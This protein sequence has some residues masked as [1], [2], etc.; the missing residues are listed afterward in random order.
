MLNDFYIL[1]I[2]GQRIG[3]N[4][5][6]KDF[7]TEGWNLSIRR[8]VNLSCSEILNLLHNLFIKHND[9][10]RSIYPIEWGEEKH[11]VYWI[12]EHLSTSLGFCWT[13]MCGIPLSATFL[14]EQL[15]V[16]ADS[17]VGLKLI[18]AIDWMLALS[19]RWRNLSL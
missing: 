11:M 8:L 16:I 3:F 13:D 5:L 18:A 7:K 15:E 9:R 2:H 17:V 14:H 4:L 6:G 12:I 1:F 19:Q 10:G